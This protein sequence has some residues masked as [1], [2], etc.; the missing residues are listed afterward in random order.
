MAPTVTATQCGTGAAGGMCLT[1]KVLTGISGTQTGV[2]AT[3]ITVTTP[4]LAITPGHTGSVVYGA[5]G[6][7]NSATAFTAAAGTTFTQNVS[8]TTDGTVYST[9]R[10]TSTVTSGTPITLGGSA[11]PGGTAGFIDIALAEILNSGTLTEDASSP[12]VV[13]TTTAQALTTASF[14]PPTPALIVAMVSTDATGSGAV[15]MTVTDTQGLTWTQQASASGSGTA[16][17]GVWIA[18]VGAVTLTASASR[19]ETVTISAVAAKAS[20]IYAAATA[21]HLTGGPSRL[22][23]ASIAAGATLSGGGSITNG[24]QLIG[25]FTGSPSSALNMSTNTGPNA[26]LGSASYPLPSVQTVLTSPLKSIPTPSRGYF[27]IDGTSELTD[28]A[29]YW[30]SGSGTTYV[31][32]NNYTNKGGIVPGGGLTIDGYAVA[33]G[34]EVFQFMDF[35]ETFGFD[36]PGPSVL[37]RGCR[38]RGGASAPGFFGTEAGG[39]W[40]SSLYIHFCDLG[41]ADPSANLAIV[42]IDVEQGANLRCYRNYISYVTTGIQPNMGTFCDVIQNFIEKLT[43]SGT[44]HLNGISINGGNSN[45]LLTANRIVTALND[46]NGVQVNQTD[47]ISMF[48]DFGTFPGTGTNSDSSVGYWVTN[49][50]VGGT[51]YCFY[52]GQNAGTAASTVNNVHFNGNSVT[53][54]SYSTGGNFGAATAIPAWSSYGNTET[55]NLWAD[56]A[57]AGTSF[58]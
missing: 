3:S 18:P 5:A 26:L 40:T 29:A 39:T 8:D 32:N 6:S 34:T 20:G 31:A 7:G 25:M 15:T 46:D 28:I 4:E 36:S 56:G 9:F 52:I 54:S 33:A 43:N 49:N 14:T 21:L 27:G 57:S 42:A 24:S 12:A 19:A 17:S 13:S 11:P 30:T 55:G 16:Y 45:F 10:S 37:F 38:I 2:T 58:I 47:C 50:Y 53:T 51:G 35:P 1:V 48:Q 22:I 23:T 41:G 44:S